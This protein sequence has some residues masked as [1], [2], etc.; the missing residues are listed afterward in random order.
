MDSSVGLR[1]PPPNVS[2]T[3]ELGRRAY[4]STVPI[5]AGESRTLA[6]DV[7]GTI[8]LADD[9]WYQ[10][11]LPRQPSLLPNEAEISLSVPPGWRIADTRG[12]VESLDG[13]HAKAALRLDTDHR[14]SLRLERSA[15]SR[16]WARIRR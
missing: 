11:D 13:R 2:S 10:L 7:E 14:I 9:G 3:S 8:R 15:W 1:N 12:G 16:L 5:P 6:L 4:S